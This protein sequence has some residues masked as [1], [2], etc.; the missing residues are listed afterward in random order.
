MYAYLC[1]CIFRKLYKEEKTVVVQFCEFF[2][3]AKTKHGP[4]SFFTGIPNL[5]SLIL[6]KLNIFSPN[7]F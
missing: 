4:Q 3:R 1:I 5:I 2:R 7:Q 6:V